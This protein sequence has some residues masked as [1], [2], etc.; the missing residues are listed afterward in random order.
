MILKKKYKDNYLN[1]CIILYI[2][3]WNKSTRFKVIKTYNQT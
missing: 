1:L 2:V 3:N